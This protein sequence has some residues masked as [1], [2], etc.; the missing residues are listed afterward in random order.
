MA[1]KFKTFS[2]CKLNKLADESK[3]LIK[4]LP[5]KGSSGFLMGE[6]G[7]LMISE[8]LYKAFQ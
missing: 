2:F 6:P 7:K 1:E 3:K 8:G 5:K 4:K